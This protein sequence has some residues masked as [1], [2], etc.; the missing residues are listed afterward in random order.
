MPVPTHIVTMPY[1]SCRRR[2]ACT[3]V[4]ARIAPVEV[5]ER[6]P[7]LATGLPGTRSRT[8]ALDEGPRAETTLEALAKLRTVFASARDPSGKAT[9]LGSVTAGSRQSAGLFVWSVR[10]QP[11]RSTAVAPALCRSTQSELSPSSSRI[12]PS[13][14]AMNS[15][16]F[17]PTTLARPECTGCVAH[18]WRSLRR[19]CAD[20]RPGGEV[21]IFR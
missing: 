1:F 2:S 7:D 15:P 8:V 16:S 18:Q 17:V 14:S 11:P 10:C 21:L 20:S 6:Y 5:I 13:F 4:A 12:V 3:T 9:G 19:R